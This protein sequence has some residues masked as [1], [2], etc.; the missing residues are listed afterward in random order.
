MQRRYKTDNIINC[1]DL[2]G[3]ACDGGVT[4]FGKVLRAGV[5]RDPSERDLEVLRRF[6]VKTVID[7]RGNSE[8]EDMPSFFKN[9]P[10]FD[11]HHISLLEANPAFAKN[12]MSLS[13]LYMHCL[14]EYK[15]NFAAVLR[16]IA[17]LD[18]PFMFHCFCGKDRTGLIAAMLLAAAGVERTDILTDYEISYTCIKNFIE[19]EIRENT[20]LIWDGAYSRFYSKAE[21]MAQILDYIDLTYGSVNGYFAQIGL[22]ENEIAKIAEVLK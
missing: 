9:N 14:N 11:Y 3:Y 20:G 21:D 16:L 4:A 13:E 8:A 10:E 7:L 2:G 1:R 12:D 17:T 18:K 6:G 5:A 15:A 22:T 19:K